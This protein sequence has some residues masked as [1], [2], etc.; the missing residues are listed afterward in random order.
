MVFGLGK[1]SGKQIVRR[2]VAA[3]N[4]RDIAGIAPLLH[5]R[6]R[7]ID[8][9]GEWIEGRE[10]IVAATQRFFAIEPRFR[11]R[12]DSVVEHDGELLLRGEAFASNPLFADDA[13]WSARIEDGGIVFWQAFGPQSA[14]RLARILSGTG[15]AALEQAEGPRA[16]QHLQ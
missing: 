6:C 11:L 14:P 1:P 7:F 12:I 2:Y 8:S 3:L 4:A 5:P 13:I 16:G 15:E 10:A 9:H